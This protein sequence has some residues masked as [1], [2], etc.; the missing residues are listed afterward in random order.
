MMMQKRRAMC[1]SKGRLF[2]CTKQETNVIF[3]TQ[4]AIKDVLLPEEEEEAE[5]TGFYNYSRLFG[6]ISH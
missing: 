6:H 3:V 1:V 2:G 5:I 4:L